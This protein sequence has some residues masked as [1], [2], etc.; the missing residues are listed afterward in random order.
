MDLIENAEIV[1]VKIQNLTNDSPL[2]SC[3]CG[4]YSGPHDG[5]NPQT[6]DR[7]GTMNTDMRGISVTGGDVLVDGTMNLMRN[8]VSSFG[9][10]AGFDLMEDSILEFEEDSEIRIKDLTS[11]VKVDED[12]Y[13]MLRRIHKTPYPNNFEM[14]FINA[15]DDSVV[16]NK[17]DSEWF[18]CELPG[19]MKKYTYAPTLEP[20]YYPTLEPIDTSTTT[21]TTTTDSPESSESDVLVVNGTT[22]AA[23]T[24]HK[25]DRYGTD[26]PTADPTNVPTPD[27]VDSSEGTAS[28]T[29]AE[30]TP[31]PITR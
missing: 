10:V 15:Q 6:R 28:P 19:F 25:N 5:G 30:D 26:E 23:P 20:T 16:I 24:S 2:A 11:A 3:A 1:N 7:Q 31:S 18:D 27:P 21:T 9:D 22:T 4:N 8:L 14:C 13:K 17:P 29:N 12:L